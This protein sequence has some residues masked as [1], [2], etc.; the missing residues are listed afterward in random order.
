MLIKQFFGIAVAAALVTACSGTNETATNASATSAAAADASVPTALAGG[1]LFALAA[2]WRNPSG[3]TVHLRD[4]QGHV[5]IV[6]MIYTSC[7]M[8]CPLIMADLRRVESAL[9]PAELAQA[10]FVLVSLDP[11]RDTPGRLREWTDEQKLDTNRWWLL[12][13]SNDA[14][15]EFAAMVDVR[16]Q[17]QDDGEIAH[18]NSISVLDRDG[19]MVFQHP[20]LG[21]ASEIAQA[22][23]RTIKP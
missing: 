23:E 7:Q 21:G 17:R 1:S 19:R 15:R 13:G 20:G 8:T 12:S 16:Y 4:L 14:V 9:T 22:V 11:D 5:S 3:D 18:T 2:D 6:T 10:R